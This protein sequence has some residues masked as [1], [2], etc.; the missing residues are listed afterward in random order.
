MFRRGAFALIALL[1]LGGCGSSAKISRGSG[2]GIAAVQALAANGERLRIA[3]GGI[4]DKTDPLSEDSLSRQLGRINASRSL[5]DAM[6]PDAV[7]ASLRDMLVT[8]L[9]GA[10]RYIVLDRDLLDTVLIEQEFSQSAKA[11][12]VT[13]LPLGE[14]E[15]AQLLVIGAITAF[16]AGTDGA[17]V[18]IPVPLSK[19]GDFGIV[20]L[21]FA[22]GHVAMDLRVVDVRSGRIVQSVAVEGSNSRWGMNFSAFLRGDDGYVQLPGVLNYFANTPVEKALQKMVTAAVDHLVAMTGPAPAA[23]APA[24]APEP[25]N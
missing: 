15:G 7:T 5:D 4:V 1:A 19:H 22:R 18:P 2:P 14:L 17:A 9:F 25:V 3:V 16:D 21:S 12:D 10:D 13:R 6:Q 8:E 11:G 20:Q 23:L 24:A